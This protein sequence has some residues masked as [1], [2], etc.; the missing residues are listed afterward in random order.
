MFYSQSGEDRALYDKYLNYRDGFFIEL[1]A[2]DGILYSNTLFFEKNLNWNGI[3]IEPT[4]QYQ[5]LQQNRPKCNNFNCAVTK[6]KGRVK[7]LG[8]GPCGGVVD[9]MP[10]G[11]RVG[12]NIQGEVYEVDSSPISDLIKDLKIQKVDLFSI[13]VEGGELQV[14]ETFD[15]NIPVYVVLIEMSRYVPQKDEMCRNFLRTYGFEHDQSIV[16]NYG[17]EEVWVNKNNKRI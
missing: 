9:T 5:H 12:N 14:L 1:G 8:N 13:D 3:L 7:F 16:L 15:W 6:N 2:G 11:H 10:D 4:N 17:V